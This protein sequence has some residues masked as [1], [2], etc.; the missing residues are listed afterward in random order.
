MQLNKKTDIVSTD[1]AGFLNIPDD[2][3]FFFMM[4]INTLYMVNGRTNDL[5][6]TTLSIDFHMLLDR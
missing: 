3:H 1:D 6:K 4:D 2:F 5:A